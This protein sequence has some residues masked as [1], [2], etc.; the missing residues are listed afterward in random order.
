MG[1]KYQCECKHIPSSSVPSAF[2]FLLLGSLPLFIM[3][4]FKLG[5]AHF[6]LKSFIAA[7]AA[8]V[9]ITEVGTVVDII[10]VRLVTLA[11]ETVVA[12]AAGDTSCK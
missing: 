2:R 8:D 1:V 12:G 5:L 10:V 9:V 6:F 11:I 7:A 4:S 3:D